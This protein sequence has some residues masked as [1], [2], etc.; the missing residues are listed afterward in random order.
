MYVHNNNLLNSHNNYTFNKI[1]AA[2][3]KCFHHF[4]LIP[5]QCSIALWSTRLGARPQHEASSLPGP[6]AQPPRGCRPHVAGDIPAKR[7]VRGAPCCRT[8]TSLSAS[9]VVASQ[10]TPSTGRNH[11][12]LV[13]AT[14]GQFANPR[15]L[16]YFTR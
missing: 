11:H 1:K 5:L 15:P 13:V 12:L 3:T 6:G 2:S 7:G 8:S 16:R 10:V 9:R 4:T 14:L